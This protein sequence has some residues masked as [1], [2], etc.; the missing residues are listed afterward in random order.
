MGF[1]TE[2]TDHSCSLVSPKSTFKVVVESCKTN[3]IAVSKATLR[4]DPPPYNVYRDTVTLDGNKGKVITDTRS[5]HKLCQCIG[6]CNF[7]KVNSSS[8][9][10]YGFVSF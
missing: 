8:S 2:A 6:V 3:L 7:E 9:G 4:T 10:D 5:R 1:S